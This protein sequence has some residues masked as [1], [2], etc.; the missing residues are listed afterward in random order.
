LLL[1][2]RDYCRS[3]RDALATMPGAA[4]A[5]QSAPVGS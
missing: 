3:L 1:E 2:Q 4:A 5:G